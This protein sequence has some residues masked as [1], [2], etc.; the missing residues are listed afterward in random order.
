MRAQSMVHA[1]TLVNQARQ[2]GLDRRGGLLSIVRGS[3]GRL[4]VEAR[5]LRSEGLNCWAEVFSV[6]HPEGERRKVIVPTIPD[7]LKGMQP[8]GVEILSAD[9]INQ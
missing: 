2:F 8:N 9:D 3:D 6:R 7:N 1:M 4:S 5:V